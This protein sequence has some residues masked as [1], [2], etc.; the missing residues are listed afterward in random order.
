VS[1]PSGTVALDPGTTALVTVEDDAST[2]VAVAAGHGVLVEPHGSTPLPAG[3]VALA[4]IGG[5]AQVDRAAPDEIEADPLVAHNRD[6]DT[7]L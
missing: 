1:V 5:P 2:F 6:L 3:S 7:Q 4:P